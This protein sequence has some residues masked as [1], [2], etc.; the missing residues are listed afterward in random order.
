MISFFSWCST[1][2]HHQITRKPRNRNG[3]NK[4]AWFSLLFVPQPSQPS[5][6]LTSLQTVARACMMCG[7]MAYLHILTRVLTVHERVTPQK[8][9]FSLSGSRKPSIASYARRYRRRQGSQ[10][11]TYARRSLRRHSTAQHRKGKGRKT[12]YCA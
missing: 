8:D 3:R 9:V 2:H 12:Y 4:K 7:G 10:A 11:Q 6:H 5:I 1:R